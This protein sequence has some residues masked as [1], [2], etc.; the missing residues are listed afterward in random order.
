MTCAVQLAPVAKV[1]G[2]LLLC[3][4][5]PVTV[6]PDTAT[7]PC[8]A[9]IVND[10]L[11]LAEPTGCDPKSSDAGARVAEGVLL[12]TNSYAPIST[13]LLQVAALPDETRGLPSRSRAGRVGSFV[14]A[15]MR[16]EAVCNL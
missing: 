12:K 14:P 7:H 13:V 8:V 4:K 3:M 2:Q 16:G 10:W 11:G 1:A 9:W 5:S 15:S 6:I